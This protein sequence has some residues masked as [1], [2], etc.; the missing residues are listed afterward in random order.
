MIITAG[1]S[2]DV[3]QA[4]SVDD[5]GFAVHFET[6]GDAGQWSA[7]LETLE[8]ITPFHQWNWLEWVAPTLNCHFV[9][10][11]V[12]DNAGA[13]RGIAPMLL[14]RRALW[15]TANWV[16]FPYLGPIVPER[17]HE[18]TFTALQRW[19]ADQRIFNLQV[20]AHPSATTALD[21][22]AFC[23]AHGLTVHRD[24]TYLLQLAGRDL[25]D[26]FAGLTRNT[27]QQLRQLERRGLE[28][29]ESTTE[30]IAYLL[31]EIESETFERQGMHS[32][33]NDELGMRLA[34]DPPAL[35]IRITSAIYEGATVGVLAT[36][37]GNI[38]A[39][40]LGGVLSRYRKTNANIA[41]YWDSIAW[42]H[43][44]GSEVLDMVGVPTPGIGA[45][46]KQ[47]GGVVHSYPVAQHS[48]RFYRSLVKFK[49]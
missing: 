40:W 28:L 19:A 44:N 38:A 8:G 29:R 24:D 34:H 6:A 18:A 9:P 3:V 10:F 5:E 14:R 46:K 1:Q 13:A 11:L 45:F 15:Q 21:S 4:I 7:V 42:A 41:L 26:V 33:Y 48:S 39:G 43:G 20:S 49:S 2:N 30:E 12:I 32:P 36:L 25:D 23:A 27:R 22:E 47:F 35:P 17:F 16:P 37:G 31:P